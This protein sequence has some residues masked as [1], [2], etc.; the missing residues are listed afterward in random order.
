[1]NNINKKADFLI[2]GEGIGLFLAMRLKDK[3]KDCDI[4]IIEKEDSVGKHT[5]G[6]NSG[7]LHAGIYYKPNSLKAKVCQKGSTRL[8]QWIE[9]RGLPI[10]NC[11]KLILAQEDNLD[12]QIDML[13]KRATENGVITQIV[14]ALQINEIESK[15]RSASGRG[16]WSPNTSV[17]DP[18]KILNELERILKLRKVSFMYKSVIAE[19][20]TSKRFIK[21]LS[22]QRIE[23]GTYLTVRACSL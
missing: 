23:Y 1:M 17:T 13:H 4:T 6:R 16:L 22:G 2:I 12:D 15:A 9:D 11:G 14:D 7:V 20:N 3:Y 18:K 10:N 19:I 5:S 8:K 21:L